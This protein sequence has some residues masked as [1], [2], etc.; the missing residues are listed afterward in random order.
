MDEAR[1]LSSEHHNDVVRTK[2]KQA[3][4]PFLQGRTPAWSLRLPEPSMF[5]G[6][7]RSSV[8]SHGINRGL[9]KMTWEDGEE[10]LALIRGAKDVFAEEVTPELGLERLVH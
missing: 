1:S 4:R 3:C 6:P 8:T 5:P 10:V 9:G 7:V 2:S